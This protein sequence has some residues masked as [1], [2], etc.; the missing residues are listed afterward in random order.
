MTQTSTSHAI[1][2]LGMHRSGTSAATGALV[3]RGA[4][5]GEQLMPASPDNPKGYWENLDIFAIHEQLL[6]ALGHAWDDLRPLP[7]GWLE[8]DATIN[9]RNQLRTLISAEFLS[10]PVWVVKDPRLCHLLPLWLPLLD[11]LGVTA[12]AIIVARDPREVAA[13]IMTR[14]EWPP[15]LSRELWWQHLSAAIQASCNLPRHILAYP[16]LLADPVV[17][18]DAAVNALELPLPPATPAI[19]KKLQNFISADIRHHQAKADIL[20]GW[21]AVISLYQKLLSQPVVWDDVLTVIQSNPL[22]TG[23]LD[24]ILSEYARKHT[25]QRYELYAVH[26]QLNQIRAELEHARGELAYAWGELDTTRGELHNPWRT[27]HNPWRTRHNPSIFTT[28][29]AF[30]A[31]NPGFTLLALDPSTA[32]AE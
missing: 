8:Q 5:P 9:A 31:K 13:S 16:R 24:S 7:E 11:E 28:T 19:I 20:P 21:E 32:L 14:D 6:K 22:T 17:E 10:H 30:I 29:T 12:S 3:L 25:A 15:E 18:I 26:D 1:L 23:P 27:R 2:M 4:W